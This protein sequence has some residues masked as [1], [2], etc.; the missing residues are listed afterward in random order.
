M[1][2]D[3]TRANVVWDEKKGELTGGLSYGGRGERAS[4]KSMKKVFYCLFFKYS[5][6]FK[7]LALK[8]EEISKN[9]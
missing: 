2:A 5:Q 1:Q 3:W 7:Y 9:K 6:F 8:K 4:S